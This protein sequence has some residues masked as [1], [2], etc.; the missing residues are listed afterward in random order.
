MCVL[1]RLY[2]ILVTSACILMTH[3]T[4]CESFS[5]AGSHARWET[6]EVLGNEKPSGR[7]CI[8]NHGIWTATMDLSLPAWLVYVSAAFHRMP[9]H[10]P[11]ANTLTR[12]IVLLLA[13]ATVS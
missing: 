6:P 3:C 12:R 10:A 9:Q 7:S 11:H 2:G 1:A 4:G 13:Q 5:A 8:T